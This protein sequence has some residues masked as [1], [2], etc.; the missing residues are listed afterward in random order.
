MAAK[1]TKEKDEEYW[2]QY[3]NLQHV[4]HQLIRKYLGGWLPKLGLGFFRGKVLYIDT[5]AGRGTHLVG[6]LGSPLVALDTLLTHRALPDLLKR[7]KFHLSFIERDEENRAALTEELKRYAVPPGV[8]I[9]TVAGDAFSQLS[10]L[11]SGIKALGKEMAP[12]FIFVDPYGFKVPGALLRELFEIGR[13]ELF[14]NV[15]WRELDMAIAHARSGHEGFVDVVTNIFDGPEWREAID[16]DANAEIRAEQAVDLLATK[17]GAKWA[18]H[19]RMLGENGATRYLLVHFTDH[20]DGRD[21]MK[22][23]MWKVCPDGGFYA[24]KGDNPAQQVLITQEPDLR[25]LKQ[26]VL[27]ELAA[28]AKR[29][30][31]LDD[32][33]RAEPWRLA[34]LGEVIRTLRRDQTIV[35]ENYDG[36]FS[37]AADPLL[38]LA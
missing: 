18:T 10:S 12:A 27:M 36:R 26:W 7:T 21:L 15:I 11:V 34:H 29:W 14:I 25:P 38:R 30:S 31:E 20:D 23:C 35:A 8:K 37:R 13:T 9:D 2:Q 5:H 3:S 32:A 24:R 6:H 16:S 4:K 1:S 17:I 22:D 28:G 33:V 19:I